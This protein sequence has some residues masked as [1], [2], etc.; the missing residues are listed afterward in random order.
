VVPDGVRVRRHRGV[1]TPGLVNAHA[2]LEYGPPFAD[3]ATSGLPFAAWI[4]ELTAR[5]RGMDDAD[6]LASARGSVHG[7][8][9]T[10]TTCVADRPRHRLAGQQS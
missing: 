10:G 1:L 9:R 6:W 2:H 3:L 4:A 5:R 8:L 7:L